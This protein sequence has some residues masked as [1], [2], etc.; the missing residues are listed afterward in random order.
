MKKRYIFLSV[1]VLIVVG[2]YF[3]APSLESI[4]QKVVHKYGSELP[5]P[6]LILKASGSD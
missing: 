2:I 6:T 5:A 1:L 4:V 3:F